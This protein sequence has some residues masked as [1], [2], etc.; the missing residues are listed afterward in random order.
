MATKAISFLGYTP[1]TKPY[2]ETTYCLGDQ[3]CTTP[4]MAEATAHFFQPDMLLVLVTREAKAQNYDALARRIDASVVLRPVDIP[5]GKTEQELWEIFARIAEEITSADTIIFD[6]T[7]GFRSLPVIAFLA[8]SYVRVVRRASVSHL[9]YGAYDATVAGRTPVFDLTSFVQL[10]DW[11]AAT[12]AFLQYGRAD[13]LTGLV[14]GAAGQ[15]GDAEETTVLEDIADRLQ[16]L[17]MA[18]Q[19]VRSRE[20]MQTAYSLR[21]RI[22]AGRT[23]SSAT[24][25]PFG[26]LLDRIGAEYGVLGLE[27]PTRQTSALQVLE[28]QREIID[29]YIEKGLYVE[30]LILAREWVISFVLAQTQRPLFERPDREAATDALNQQASPIDLGELPSAHELGKLWRRIR[31]LRNDVAHGA[32]QEQPT[33]TAMV[34]AEIRSFA[35]DLNSLSME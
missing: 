14:R 18:L 32:M 28:K 34:I 11:T 13:A 30:A 9:I 16:D 29:W 5:S 4:F 35:L 12:D 25:E 27:R 21:R 19:T 7:N 10:L 3:E 1:P 22:E 23:R 20:I 31:R 26:L 24:T 33:P 8:A 6:I 17:S 15:R 2:Q